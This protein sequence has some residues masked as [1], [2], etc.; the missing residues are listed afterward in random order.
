VVDEAPD[1]AS[2]CLPK[3]GSCV[4]DTSCMRSG[5]DE[6]QT[7]ATSQGRLLGCTII[8]LLLA[9]CTG[10][11][12]SSLTEGAKADSEDAYALAL[13]QAVTRYRGGI[14]PYVH[15]PNSLGMRARLDALVSLTHEFYLTLVA[16]EP[17]SSAGARDVADAIQDAVGR[18]DAY[19]RA[20]RAAPTR[21]SEDALVRDVT[22]AMAVVS[23]VWH[24]NFDAPSDVVMFLE[25]A[26]APADIESLTQEVKAIP[27]VRSVTYESKEDACIV[28]LHTFRDATL[29]D[30]SE[31]P[32]SLRIT[33]TNG[34][35]PSSDVAI[36]FENHPDVDEV[37]DFYTYY[38]GPASVLGLSEEPFPM[39]TELSGLL[40]AEKR[41]A[42]W[43]PGP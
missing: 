5:E 33:L 37:K 20:L 38:R 3:G 35:K 19:L 15:S 1:S 11:R 21:W 7:G 28:F 31:L 25:D 2:G 23:L 16:S 26:A 41:C 12:V 4:S 10:E 13:C 34:G 42:G 6:W 40:R 14:D 32:A 29:A 27:E 39:L 8:L 9:G 17:P 24:L 43:A 22:P 30:C 18:S 36:L